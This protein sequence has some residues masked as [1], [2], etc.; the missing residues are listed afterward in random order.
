[1]QPLPQY[2]SE[3][4][5]SVREA[6]SFPLGI[7]L[8]KK[9]YICP[10]ATKSEIDIDTMK[11]L[12]L[13]FAFAAI[14][15][16]SAAQDRIVKQN[17]EEIRGKILRVGGS[18]IEYTREGDYKGPVLSL[19]TGDVVLIEYGDGRKEVFNTAPVQS[20]RVRA[21]Y[22]DNFPHYQ[23]EI[24]AAYGVGLGDGDTDRVL[25][26]TVHGVRLSPYAF[27]G[28]GAGL[29]YFYESVGDDN[30]SGMVSV[31]ANAKGYYPVSAGTQIYLSLDLGAS[32]GAWSYLKDKRDMYT[33]VG[34]GVSIG[35]TK[36]RMRCDL[37][38]R[39]QYMGK[40][41]GALLFRIGFGF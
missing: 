13:F 17:A 41:T 8:P 16:T 6:D 10:K 3:G 9:H 25:F 22:K 18:K 24:A 26:E 1:M 11:K 20:K 37:G 38:I 40:D 29:N 30:G 14:C 21:L 31:F 15:G 32:I 19:S 12:L 23:G 33:A 35:S 27:I 36:N 4:S 28:A 7:Q 34:P 5:A 2:L 39:Y